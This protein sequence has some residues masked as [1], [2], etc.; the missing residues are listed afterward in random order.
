MPVS[1]STSTSAM[2]TPPTPQLV[3]SGLFLAA[4]ESLWPRTVIGTAP[5]FAQACFQVS[6]R[7]GSSL[8][9]IVPLTHSSS[10]GFAFKAGAAFANNAS[11]ASTAARRVDELTPPGVVD[12]P[13]PPDGGYIVS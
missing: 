7:L 13:D 1:V 5:I 6:E 2:P 9:R 3:R 12:P 10:S 11:R 8:T 4:A